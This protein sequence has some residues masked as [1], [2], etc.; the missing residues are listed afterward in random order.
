MEVKTLTIWEMILITL[1]TGGLG[2][3]YILFRNASDSR[4]L[5][6]QANEIALMTTAE[7]QEYRACLRESEAP[8]KRNFTRS[9][10]GVAIFFALFAYAQRKAE[11]CGDA[12][13]RPAHLVYLQH[14]DNERRDQ[15]RV[16]KELER[17]KKGLPRFAKYPQL[18]ADWDK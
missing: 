12:C 17:V 16:K 9:L 18:K 4:K 5:G 3:I 2:V 7:K 8:K 10:A 11:D 6:V 1:F 15:H 14:P 13:L